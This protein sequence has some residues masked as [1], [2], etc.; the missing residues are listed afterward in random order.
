MWE[1]RRVTDRTTHGSQS[2]G[3][4]RD[5][6]QRTRG[7]AE[8]RT[9]EARSGRAVGRAEGGRAGRGEEVDQIFVLTSYFLE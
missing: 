8:R 4:S 1:E 9:W 5:G 7:G 6:E 2:E 3:R